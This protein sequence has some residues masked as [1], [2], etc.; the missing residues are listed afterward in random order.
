MKNYRLTFNGIYS[1]VIFTTIIKA[2]SMRGAERK[3]KNLEP[4][5]WTS[6]TITDLEHEFN[7]KLDKIEFNY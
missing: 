1:N 7:L 3:A 2:K 6:R 5:T 4:F